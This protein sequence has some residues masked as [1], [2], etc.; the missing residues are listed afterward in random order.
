MYSGVMNTNRNALTATMTATDGTV[1]LAVSNGDSFS[2]TDGATFVSRL[3][4][5]LR[6]AGYIRSA[7]SS[8]DAG[9]VATLTFIV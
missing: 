2:V 7:Y 1:T 8:S 5:K 3:D 9:M 6:S 4:R